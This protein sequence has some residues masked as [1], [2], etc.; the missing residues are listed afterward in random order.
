ME[1]KVIRHGTHRIGNDWDGY[2]YSL[3][4]SKGYSFNSHLHKCYELIHVLEGR[5]LY[6]V[7]GHEYTI[8]DGDI[9]I[10]SPVELHSFSF[11]AVCD[12]QREFLH[13]YPGFLERC[14]EA[15]SMLASRKKGEFNHIP[16]VK[17]AQYGLDKIFESIRKSCEKVSEETDLIV[18]ANTLIFIA[19]VHRMLSEDAPQYPEEEKKRSHS[20]YDYIDHHYMEDINSK[21][22]AAE[23][24]MSVSGAERLFKR[25][26][27]M[28]IKAYLT[29]RRVTAAKNLMIEGHKAMNAYARCGFRDYSTF[30]RAFVKYTG[31]TPDKFKGS[32]RDENGE[33]R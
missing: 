9:I 31:M 11:P 29:L 21:S 30:Y 5:F 33:S 14:P 15:A 10:T 26:T 16:S 1:K 13:I 19:E 32:P 18:Y 24:F 6:T 17:V 8:S 20:I 4:H 3:N 7:E 12:Y 23:M 28:T 2:M 22:V 25:E 27:G